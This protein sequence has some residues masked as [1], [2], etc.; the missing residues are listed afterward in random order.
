[1]TGWQMTFGGLILTFAGILTGGHLQGF[2]P[3]SILLLAYMA[4]LSSLAFGKYNPVGRVAIYNFLVPV[5]GVDSRRS[6]STSE[7][8]PG[9]TWW[10]WDWFVQGFR[11]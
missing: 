10:R 1:M 6:F 5:F 7:C 9:N 4:P 2:T 11:W 3:V 8:S